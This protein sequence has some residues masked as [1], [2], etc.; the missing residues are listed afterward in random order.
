MLKICCKKRTIVYLFAILITFV[1]QNKLYC[2]DEVFNPVIPDNDSQQAHNQKKRTAVVRSRSKIKACE[3]GDLVAEV[4]VRLAN[5]SDEEEWPNPPNDSQLK[6]KRML[7]ADS[8]AAKLQTVTIMSIAG[9]TSS[10]IKM[11]EMPIPLPIVKEKAAFKVEEYIDDM[12]VQFFREKHKS[13]K[14]IVMAAIVNEMLH[15]EMRPDPLSGSEFSRLDYSLIPPMLKNE[16]MRLGGTLEELHN[17]VE[18]TKRARPSPIR[19]PAYGKTEEGKSDFYSPAG[20]AVLGRRDLNDARQKGVVRKLDLGAH[21]VPVTPETAE[22]R[23]AREERQYRAF[24]ESEKGRGKSENQLKKELQSELELFQDYLNYVKRRKLENGVEGEEVD[25]SDDD[26][27][28]NIPQV[29]PTEIDDDDGGEIETLASKITKRELEEQ[30]EKLVGK[31]LIHLVVDGYDLYFSKDTLDLNRIQKD[32][33]SN[34]DA[35]KDLERTPIGA[36]GKPMNYHHL[37]H[38]D[39][40]T[41][42]TKSIIL[43]ITDNLHK[44]YSGLLHFGAQTYRLPKNRVDRKKFNTARDKFNTEIVKALSSSH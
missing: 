30:F 20:K 42:K 14:D 26:E 10:L 12:V 40:K 43:L 13:E 23:L 6:K 38:Y 1:W 8:E 4:N 41:H 9:S 36:D 2:S 31:H 34:R 16:F 11:E 3:V 35:M 17:A 21:I 18:L 33:L 7:E 39:A 44:R 25:L 15:H 22:E 19:N 32:G 29:T 24:V 5:K 28:N 27:D 37:T